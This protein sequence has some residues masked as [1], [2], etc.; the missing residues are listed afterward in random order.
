MTDP[1]VPT[2]RAGGGEGSRVKKKGL[3]RR[4][5]PRFLALACRSSH[6]GT[7]ALAFLL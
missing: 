4:Y 2:S 5:E 3:I 7:L 6:A 1:L